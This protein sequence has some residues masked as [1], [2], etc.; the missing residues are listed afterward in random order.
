MEAIFLKFVDDKEKH[1]DLTNLI[2]NVG[3]KM[4]KCTNQKFNYKE[5]HDD[6]NCIENLN[7]II[8]VIRFGYGTWEIQYDKSGFYTLKSSHYYNNGERRGGSTTGCCFGSLWMFCK[9]LDLVMERDENADLIPVVIMSRQY[10]DKKI[11]QKVR[12]VQGMPLSSDTDTD[13]HK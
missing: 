3:Q 10:V 13:S 12:T 7:E 6:F 5:D 1:L 8:D 9:F 4:L 11:K 2:S